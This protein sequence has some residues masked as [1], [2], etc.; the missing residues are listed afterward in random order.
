MRR[1]AGAIAWAACGVTVTLA[2]ARL[3]LAIA[4]PESSSADSGPLVPGGGIPVAA[5]EALV[6]ILLGVIGA[7]VASRQPRNAVAGSCA[8]SGFRLDC[9]S[10]AATST[11]ALL[12]NI[13]RE[14]AWRSS[15]GG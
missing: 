13:P 2:A 11:G 3:V 6:L 15:W 4:D 10:S 1:R 9:W 7:V 14:M 8:R 5:F 12:S